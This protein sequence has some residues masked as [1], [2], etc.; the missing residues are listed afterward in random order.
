MS[1][2]K[3]FN[4]TAIK[5]EQDVKRNREANDAKYCREETH[6]SIDNL[7]F[8]FEKLLESVPEQVLITLEIKQ[9][10]ENVYYHIGKIKGLL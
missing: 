2:I 1:E 4:R 10:V 3:E 7:H 8:S 6:N 9:H 5:S